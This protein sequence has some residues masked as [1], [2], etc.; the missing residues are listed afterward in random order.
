MYEC[1]REGWGCEGAEEQWDIGE[2]EE[3]EPDNAEIKK[4]E[5]KERKAR[6]GMTER[7]SQ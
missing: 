6:A 1:F 5:I 3:A 2:A 4:M 7:I